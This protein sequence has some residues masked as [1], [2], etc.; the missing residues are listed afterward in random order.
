M[1]EKVFPYYAEAVLSDGKS[2][3]LDLEERGWANKELLSKTVRWTLADKATNM[4][5]VSVQIPEGGKPVFKSRVY[6]AVSMGQE[7]SEENTS[8]RCYGIGYKY[9]RRTHWFWVLPG[10]TI[11]VGE[12]PVLADRLWQ[13]RF[14]VNPN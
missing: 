7:I 14:G 1:S 3:A 4:P 13:A 2:Y 10:G 11:E 5:V 9:G 8:F 6:G 12:N